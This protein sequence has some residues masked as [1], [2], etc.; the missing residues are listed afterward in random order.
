MDAD[1]LPGMDTLLDRAFIKVKLLSTIFRTNENRYLS[2]A[3]TAR[4]TGWSMS[5][6]G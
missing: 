3:L 2:P 1:I 4:L 5:F 6:T